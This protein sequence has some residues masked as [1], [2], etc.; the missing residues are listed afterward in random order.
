MLT[1]DTYPGSHQDAEGKLHGQVLAVVLA[2]D[3]LGGP[4]WPAA[5]YHYGAL[6]LACKCQ[7]GGSAP[8]QHP[9]E[10]DEVGDAQHASQ[11]T[12]QTQ[13]AVL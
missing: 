5:E 3:V 10:D 2:S 11:E 6:Q 7:G 1:A 13:P 9:Y 8:A 4:V 12:Q